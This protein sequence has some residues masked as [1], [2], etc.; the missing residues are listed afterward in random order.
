MNYLEKQIFAVWIGMGDTL[1]RDSKMW[2]PGGTEGQ[3]TAQPNF[4]LY[5]WL[6]KSPLNYTSKFQL[7]LK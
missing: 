5:L 4:I 6:D 1:L 7:E 2:E 3:I